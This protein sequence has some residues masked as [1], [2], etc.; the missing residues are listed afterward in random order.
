[1]RVARLVTGPL[2]SFDELEEA[3]GEVEKLGLSNIPDLE[4]YGSNED[5]NSQTIAE[6]ARR[7]LASTRSCSFVKG[8]V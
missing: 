5:D 2:D 3:K 8:A 6:L 7:L 1:M 4:D